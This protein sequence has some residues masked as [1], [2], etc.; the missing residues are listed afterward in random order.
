MTEQTNSD[1]Y[2][3][4]NDSNYY[5]DDYDCCYYEYSLCSYINAIHNDDFDRFKDIYEHGI[6]L[7]PVIYDGLFSH[8]HMPSRNGENI[9]RFMREHGC[10]NDPDVVMKNMNR[11]FVSLVYIR[12]G[13]PFDENKVVRYVIKHITDND[14]W[15]EI[16]QFIR[17]LIRE[18][19]VNIDIKELLLFE[20][21][22]NKISQT[23][24]N[25]IIPINIDK[26]ENNSVGM[27]N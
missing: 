14:S 6:E 8:P 22:N 1:D 7:D 4:E 12:S 26:I 16:H 24:Y 13:I 21:K 18:N 27:I 9:V 20:L 17:A 10:M 5:Y 23:E 19:L 25:E 15:G 3:Y 11:P 2:D